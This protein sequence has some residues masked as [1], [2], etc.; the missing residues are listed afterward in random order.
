MAVAL[1]AAACN[2]DGD[3]E[4]LTLEQYLDELER[5]SLQ[6]QAAPSE[7]IPPDGLGSFEDVRAYALEQWDDSSAAF[8]DYVHDLRDLEPPDAAHDVH[9]R[10]VELLSGYV[11]KVDT[12][13]Q[14]IADAES[15]A[16]LEAIS[17]QDDAFFTG[18]D[19]T[20]L[21]EICED[22]HELANNEGLDIEDFECDEPLETSD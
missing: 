14:Q 9:V 21:R 18:G 5:L 2:G 8:R 3:A 19:T 1:L 12:V 22:M 20:E 6:V 17:E 15:F 11:A 13:R 7:S 10:L 4:A 16:D